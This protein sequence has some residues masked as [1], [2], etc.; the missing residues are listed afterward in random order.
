MNMNEHP[1]IAV[2][3]KIIDGAILISFV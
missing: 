2:L 1:L 3:K